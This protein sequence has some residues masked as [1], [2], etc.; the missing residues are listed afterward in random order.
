MLAT[1]QR[2]PLLKLIIAWNNETMG[3]DSSCPANEYVNGDDDL[4]VCFELNDNDFF[5]TSWPAINY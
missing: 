5:S 4:P 2:T 3:V 1:V